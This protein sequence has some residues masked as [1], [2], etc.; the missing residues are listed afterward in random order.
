MGANPGPKTTAARHLNPAFV[1]WMM[2]VPDG[3]T[4]TLKGKPSKVRRARLR[5]LGNAVQPHVAQAAW[6]GLRRRLDRAQLGLE[7]VAA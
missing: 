4:A 5:L 1:E 7:A 3:W 2:G 6:L